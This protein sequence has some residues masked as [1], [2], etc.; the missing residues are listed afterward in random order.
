MC[1]LNKFNVAENGNAEV[2]WKNLKIV[3]RH[4]IPVHVLYITV[5]WLNMAQ[6]KHPRD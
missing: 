5:L 4:H 3:F 6:M 1:K 2:K